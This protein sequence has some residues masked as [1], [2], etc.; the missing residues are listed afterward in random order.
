MLLYVKLLL[1]CAIP[2]ISFYSICKLCLLSLFIPEK[3]GDCVFQ[4]RLETLSFLIT[5]WFASASSVLSAMLFRCRLRWKYIQMSL[6]VKFCLLPA[7]YSRVVLIHATTANL[8]T[9]KLS[10]VFI[11]FFCGVLYGI[12]FS[13]IQYGQGNIEVFF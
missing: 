10:G 5:P 8:N 9:R 13:K 12:I 1:P 7:I 4:R 3:G 6:V 11:L 2:W